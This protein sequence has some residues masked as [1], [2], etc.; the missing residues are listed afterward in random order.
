MQQPDPHDLGMSEQRASDLDDLPDVPDMPDEPPDGGSAGG[1]GMMGD[2]DAAVRQIRRRISPFGW[3]LIV[4]VLGV[5]GGVGYYTVNSAI[6][7]AREE[8][9]TQRGRQELAG[10]I[11]QNLPQA[12][13][14][15][16]I[17][18]VY[19]HNTAEPVHRAARRLLAKLH[20][21]QSIAMQIDGLAIPG[22]ARAE[23]ALGIAEI[24]LPAAE[25]ARAPLLAALPQTD[26]QL[27]RV[28]VAW[29]LVVLN[30]PRAWTTVR[31]LLESNKLQGVHDLDSRR[32]FDPGLVARMAGRDRLIELANSNNQSSKRLAALS[33]SELATPDVIDPLTR[34]AHDT[35][36]NVAREAAIGL[37]RTGDPRA[38]D[39]IMAFLN[40]HPEERESVL[41]AL[42]TSSGAQG[43]G[44]VIHGARDL[45]TR[46]MATRLLREQRDPDAG[47]ALFEALN[48]ATGTDEVSQQMHRNA[49]FGLAD[50]GDPR[51]VDGLIQFA[52]NAT[53]HL[54]T[55]STQEAK[56]AL[57]QIRFIPGAAARARTALIALLRDPHGDFVRTPVLLDLASA[58]DPALGTEIIPFLAQPDAQEGAAVALCAL[59]NPE[60]MSRVRTQ[61]RRPPATHM[62]EATV[63]DEP[64]FISRRNAIRGIAWSGDP[65]V[66]PDLMHIIED[67]DDRGGLR[68]EAGFALAAVADD[69]TLTEIANRAMDTARPEPARLFYIWALRGRS[70]PAISNR[71]IQAY[72]KHG[73]NPD[74]MRAAAISAG[75]GADDST[76][77]LLI[78]LL[79]G[80]GPDAQDP[81]VRFAA[82]IATILGG[83]A[84]A[85]GALLDLL[86]ANDELAGTLQNEFAPRGSN[87]NA[88]TQQENWLLLPITLPMFTDGR[89]YRRVD[90]ATLLE[91]ARGGKHF[92]FALAQLTGRLR[93]GWESAIGVG[94][95]VINTQ[96]REAA[97]GS[98]SFRQDMAFKALRALNDRGSLLSLRRQ[99][100]SPAA[101]ERA[102]HE[103][104]EMSAS[105]GAAGSPPGG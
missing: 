15:T 5:G 33:L 6:D 98:D 63:R 48:A 49:V 43:L 51:A 66:A 87:P 89:I 72:L 91:A 53:T 68:E 57:D 18:E 19:N 60:G 74:V 38:T 99:N 2:D 7:G 105:G 67:T 42:A 22:A 26:P 21:P 16:R 77:D 65:H 61:M 20:D 4:A 24:G 36:I 93:S 102:R 90:V 97:M 104:L 45:V 29:A 86:I 12:E 23:A 92:G 101:A 39:P 17:R 46:A 88:A 34:L 35:D 10:I 80:T 52:T 41:S 37:G 78:P 103:L 9:A 76:S 85:G 69:A 28:E 3:V 81:N 40:A 54:D 32:L 25:A 62:A 50:I 84:R 94:P 30:E 11:Q 100:R 83:N 55:N 73:V 58:G 82:S 64:L 56:L 44:V 47:D 71:L 27:D 14:A 8:E 70:T 95:H 1:G 59:H 79:T 75:F 13:T 31:E 96:L